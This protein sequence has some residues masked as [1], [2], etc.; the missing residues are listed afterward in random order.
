MS[1]LKH[2]INVIQRLTTA[3]ARHMCHNCMYLKRTNAVINYAIPSDEDVPGFTA[4]R[5]EL[6][7]LELEADLHGG[8][9]AVP[10]AGHVLAA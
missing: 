7:V 9:D 3:L 2:A 5:R 8:H 4:E 10:H 6:F 1:T